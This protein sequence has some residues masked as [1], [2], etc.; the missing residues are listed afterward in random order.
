MVQLGRPKDITVN[1]LVL[2][3]ATSIFA[4]TAIVGV[5]GSAN[6]AVVPTHAKATVASVQAA[7][8]KH[9]SKLI[10]NIGAIETRVASAKQLTLAEKATIKTA[11]DVGLSTV[12]ADATK[13]A[14]DT[15]IK[16]ARRDSRVALKA[17]RGV[18]RTEHKAIRVDRAAHH[19][20]HHAAEVAARA[21]HARKAQAT[22]AF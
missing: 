4:L 16:H 13:V 9:T 3:G 6:A 10:S 19:M 20:A 22:T 7:S 1:K 5:A 21:A 15:T 18:V 12:K 17:G 2:A 11:L 14:G 8:A